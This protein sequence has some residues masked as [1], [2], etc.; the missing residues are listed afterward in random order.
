MDVDTRQKLEPSY[1]EV[2]LDV[3]LNHFYI[4][5]KGSQ[6]EHPRFYR[7]GEKYLIWYKF[8]P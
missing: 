6:I 4:D 3:G 5:E 2:G 7:Q 1:S 8:C